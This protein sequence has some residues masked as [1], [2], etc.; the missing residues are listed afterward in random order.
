V[1]LASGEV[2]EL[3]E[4]IAVLARSRTAGTAMDRLRFAR[5]C[6]D[7]LAG[8]LG[9]ALAERLV[10]LGWL[11]RTSDTFEPA[12][13]LLGWLARHGHP[14]SDDRKRPLSRACLDWTERAPHVAGRVGAAL[15]TLVVRSGWVARVRDTRAL[16][17]TARGR[18]ALADEL[19]IVLG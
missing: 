11:Y 5:T 13:P 4:R 16:R 19:G 8:L 18:R 12:S 2:A 3:L 17:L 10:D 9:V 15:A 6:Y 7:H 1:R 14:V